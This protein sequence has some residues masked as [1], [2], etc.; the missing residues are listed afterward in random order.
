[1]NMNSPH[2]EIN[3]PINFTKVYHGMLSSTTGFT[4]GS[5]SVDEGAYISVLSES[6]LRG[7][8]CWGKQIE[9]NLYINALGV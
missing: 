6:T 5:T 9:Q 7:F 2:F 4:S 3:F 8:L 1:M